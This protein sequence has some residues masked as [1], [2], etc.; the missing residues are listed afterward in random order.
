MA[1]GDFVA[2]YRVSTRSQGESGL[3]L[4]AQR[5]AVQRFI[6]EGRIISEFTEVESGGR[7]DRP[8]LAQALR[9][10]RLSGA[11]L[12][13]AKLDRLSRSL[14]FL[15]RLQDSHV[16]F[17]CADLPEATEL[18]VHIYAAM[19]QHER[20]MI[21]A[22]TKAAL[23]AARERG[24]VLGN[25]RL[26]EVRCED[27][28]AARAVHVALAR[29]FRDDIRVVIGELEKTASSSAEIARELNRIGYRTRRGGMWS[30][31]Q[32]IRYQRAAA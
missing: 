21:S 27:T 15:V 3:G 12:V 10:V 13:V 6:G 32:V 16:P 31:T 14:G 20:R 5:E 11:R 8:Q 7:D 23:A 1:A 26:A 24:T 29:E 19:A 28:S 4:E 18:T 22:R 2:Y 30:T 9:M 17:V 25:P